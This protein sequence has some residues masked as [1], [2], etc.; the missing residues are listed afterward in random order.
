MESSSQDTLQAE[1][2]CRSETSQGDRTEN[3]GLTEKSDNERTNKEEIQIE[4][5]DTE[6]DKV[7]ATKDK[8]LDEPGYDVEN[9]GAKISTCIA[10]EINLEVH[11]EKISAEISSLDQ[12]LEQITDQQASF[13]EIPE[14]TVKDENTR[15]NREADAELEYSEQATS[16]SKT[17]RE[18]DAS[19][20]NSAQSLSAQRVEESTFDAASRNGDNDDDKSETQSSNLVT[21]GASTPVEIEAE[22][23]LQEA[24]YKSNVDEDKDI[25]ELEKQKIDVHPADRVAKEEDSVCLNRVVREAHEEGL[26]ESNDDGKIDEEMQD[27][28]NRDSQ[29]KSE[30]EEELGEQVSLITEKTEIAAPRENAEKRVEQ[31]PV[32]DFDEQ[33]KDQPTSKPD[34]RETSI[35]TEEVGM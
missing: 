17:I 21:D 22:E 28:E 14:N 11:E 24:S 29:E 25:Y 16:I 9:E 32:E 4:D 35:S 3:E 8:Y 18:E 1:N 26:T 6:G 19:T 10:E 2:I 27:G 30:Q 12:N 31:H 34:T 13:E 7:E 33:E 20:L 5:I 15:S 23:T